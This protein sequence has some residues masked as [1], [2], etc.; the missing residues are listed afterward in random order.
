MTQESVNPADYACVDMP[1]L[2]QRITRRVVGRLAYGLAVGGRYRYLLECGHVVRRNI[3]G[4]QWCYCA[5]CLMA[6]DG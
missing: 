6:G 2:F 1:V 4:K 5:A 3:R